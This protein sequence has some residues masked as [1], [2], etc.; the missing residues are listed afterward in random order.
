MVALSAQ[1]FHGSGIPVC[2]WFLSRDRSGVPTNGA[3]PMRDRRGSTLFIDARSAG[4]LVDLTHRELTDA[5]ID[6]IAGT[7][8]AWRGETV[9]GVQTGTAVP[10]ISAGQ[11]GLFRYLRPSIEEQRAIAS[12]LRT[13]DDEIELNRR[14]NE[15]LEALARAIFT[16]WFVDF[17]PVCAKAEGRQPIGMDAETAA[18]FP[19]SFVDSPLGPIPSGW[20]SV[21]L[22]S[23]I[24]V[25]RGLSYSGA[26]L[27]DAH[28]GGLP[29]H[30]LNS[31]QA[32]GGYQPDGLKWYTG[33]HAERHLVRPRALIIANTDLT[34]ALKVIG[35]PAIVPGRYG[36]V[37]L[38]SADLF[39]LEPRDDSQVTG[40]YLYFLLSTRRYHDEIAGFS[41]GTT[42]NHLPTDGLTRPWIAL[43]PA[44]IVERFDAIVGPMLDRQEQLHAEID[45]LAVTRDALL[46]KLVSGEV[47]VG[48]VAV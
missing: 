36:E 1:L 14:M 40:R 17:D 13:L 28:G 5:D 48:S 33:T 22:G 6:R 37:G 42:I 24:E 7:Y 3:K 8:Y 27:T 31:I 45:T 10:H 47:R 34:W 46:P 4:T 38:F 26:G 39:R 44:S 15:T 32:G 29:L 30:N 23:Q 41:N 11:I 12:V 18:L 16:S 19:D 25:V 2:L 35:A 21:R 9:L 43:S 20:Q